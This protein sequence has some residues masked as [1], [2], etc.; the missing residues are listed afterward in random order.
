[1]ETTTGMIA[2]G[3][4]ASIAAPTAAHAWEID[5]LHSSV[6]FKVRHMMV[7]NVKGE[8]R[9]IRGAA[10]VS[11]DD[12]TTAR[13]E[14]TIDVD[15]LVTG[16]AD[17]DAHLKSADFFDAAKFPTMTFT[18]KHVECISAEQYKLTGD[19]TIRGVTREV[20][21]DVEGPAPVSKNPLDGSIR[22]GAS[23][24]AKINRKD[25]GLTWNA[26][27]ETGGVLVGDEVRVSL[28]VELVRK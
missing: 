19:L 9:S 24:T 2:E 25:F 5:P 6:Q 21:F 10:I 13:I 28:E 3:V 22:T 15:S 8:F 17:R 12:P 16:V 1:M 18:S 27:L 14:A 7:S 4:L 11:D 20:V 23:A 26:A